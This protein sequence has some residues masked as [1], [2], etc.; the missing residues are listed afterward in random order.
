MKNVLSLPGCVVV[1]VV[2]A[3]PTLLVEAKGR[4]KSA[5]CPDCRWRSRSI[6]SHYCRFLSDLSVADQSASLCLQVRRFRCYNPTCSRATFAETF[7]E[8]VTP[9]A[10]RTTRL[11]EAQGKVGLAGGGEVGSALLNTLHMPTSPDSVLREIRATTLTEHPTPR[12]LGVDDWCFKRGKRYGT[13]LVDLEQRCV[14]DLL[15]ERSSEA[16]SNWLREHPGVEIISRDRATE[17]ARGANQGAPQAVQVADRWHLLKNLGDTLKQWLERHRKELSEVAKA[18]SATQRKDSRLV[19][20]RKQKLY[21]QG[22][23][24]VEQGSSV[25]AAARKLGMSRET[26]GRWLRRGSYAVRRGRTSNLTPFTPYL[27]ERWQD[28]HTNVLQLHREITARGFPGTYASVYRYIAALKEGHGE[29]WQQLVPSNKRMSLY[30]KLRVFCGKAESLTP[31]EATWL[32]GVVGQVPLAQTVYELVQSFHALIHSTSPDPIQAL[33][34]W[35]DTTTNSDVSELRK[36]ANGIRHDQAAVE[37]ALTLPWSNGQVEGQV[38]KL[39][40]IKRMMY[41]RAS[42]DLLRARVLLA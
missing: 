13:I 8:L 15:P 9:H 6:H 3:N 39:K 20:K 40:L 32:H 1:D 35:L 27:K 22:L 25:Q 42:F 17:Y 23:K 21:D 12:V 10:Q 28:G 37:A 38:N 36:F 16:L 41:G 5:C 14:V 18:M 29:L 24:L 33:S 19:I 30:D 2:S 31:K 4:C 11:K 34:G 7:P 26:L